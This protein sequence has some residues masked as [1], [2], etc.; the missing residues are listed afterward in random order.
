MKVQEVAL[1]MLH[2]AYAYEPERTPLVQVR[3][4]EVQ[5]WPN[6]TEEDW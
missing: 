4:C 2:E 5:V 6:G 3:C 1:P